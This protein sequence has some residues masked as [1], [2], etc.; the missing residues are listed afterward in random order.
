MSEA[1]ASMP[2]DEHELYRHL[3]KE[4]RH[5]LKQIYKVISNASLDP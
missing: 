3:S 5:G 1:I 4:M 2:R